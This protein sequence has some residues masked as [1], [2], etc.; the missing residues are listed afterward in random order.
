MT[1]ILNIIT[2]MKEIEADI[3]ANREQA[4]IRISDAEKL[5][6]YYDLLDQAQRYFDE[7]DLEAV[8]RRTRETIHESPYATKHKGKP[9]VQVLQEILE[10]HGKPMYITDLLQWA[11][12]QGV[13]YTGKSDL[14]N[15]IRNSLN[16]ARS[17]FVNIG[18]NTWWLADRPVPDAEE[19]KN[20][21]TV[22]LNQ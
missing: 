15:Q 2:D 21:Q 10:L 17:R 3:Q 13:K 8:I 12:R 11:Q 9:N 19:E 18:N 6:H 1:T 14:K 16:G 22:V 7:Q 5:Q 20:L 4:E